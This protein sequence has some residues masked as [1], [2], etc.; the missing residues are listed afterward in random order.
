MYQTPCHLPQIVSYCYCK[1]LK[2]IV[3]K[4]NNGSD[5]ATSRDTGHE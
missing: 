4:N 5:S 3:L 2:I 1:S